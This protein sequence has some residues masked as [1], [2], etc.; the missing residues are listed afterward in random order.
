MFRIQAVADAL[1]FIEWSRFIQMFVLRVFVGVKSKRVK[2]WSFVYPCITEIEIWWLRVTQR[3]NRVSSTWYSN[4]SKKWIPGSLNL[5][6]PY[7]SWWHNHNIRDCQSNRRPVSSSSDRFVDVIKKLTEENAH[8]WGRKYNWNTI[9]VCELNSFR[10]L[11]KEERFACWMSHTLS[12]WKKIK[13][14]FGRN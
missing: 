2:K 7:D 4:V 13:S 3:Q 6:T 11:S 14:S 5:S 10:D 12:A 8:L 1:F 9:A